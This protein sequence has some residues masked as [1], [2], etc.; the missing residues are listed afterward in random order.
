[1]GKQLITVLS[2]PEKNYTGYLTWTVFL[3]QFEFSNTL[4]FTIFIP[5]TII[6]TSTPKYWLFIN[7]S[8]PFIILSFILARLLNFSIPNAAYHIVSNLTAIISLHYRVA[9]K[10][11][12]EI[13]GNTMCW[14][15][16]WWLVSLSFEV[17]KL[18]Y[19]GLKGVWS[20]FSVDLFFPIHD[21]G[22]SYNVCNQKS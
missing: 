19:A 9:A 2:A 20:Y 15:R 21:K 10:M 16:L 12:L 6:N 1:M 11:A 4:I 17:S 5:I 3:S 13:S 14:V 18:V 22:A 7:A 8:I